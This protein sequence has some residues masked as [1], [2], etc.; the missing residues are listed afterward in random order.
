MNSMFSHSRILAAAVSLA[1]LAGCN[2][3]EDVR[4]DPF[5]D[6]PPASVVLQGTVTGLSSK[7]SIV[8]S[9]NGLLS[10]SVTVVAPPPESDY[11]NENFPVAFS[12]GTRPVR[13]A[14]GNPVPYNI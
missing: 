5:I 9:N 2:A 1:A 4:S 10:D 14:N 12:F 13:D 7:R 3:V 6:T 11:V 8:L